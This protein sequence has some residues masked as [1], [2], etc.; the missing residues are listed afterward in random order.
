MGTLSD[1]AI[2]QSVSPSVCPMAQL[3]Y[4]RAGCLQLSHVRTAD[5]SVDGRGSAASRTAI[6]GGISSRHSRGDNLFYFRF[7]VWT[8]YRSPAAAACGWFAAGRP[9]GTAYQLSIDVCCMRRRS[10]ANVGSVTPRDE[11]RGSTQTGA[12]RAKKVGPQT[13]GH[14]LSN[15][16]R[17][18]KNSL[19]DSWVNL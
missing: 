10:A 15:L 7:D 12:G 18:K 2:L 17:F 6:G 16:N 14:I 1:T 8:S 4:V 13:D 5:L 19:E 11:V 9:V 3:P